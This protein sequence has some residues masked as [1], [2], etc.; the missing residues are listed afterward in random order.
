M[1]GAITYY[2]DHEA[3]S[4]EELKLNVTEQCFARI[5]DKTEEWNEKKWN[6]YLM[7]EIILFFELNGTYFNPYF[8]Q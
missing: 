4:S 6:F 5:H 1:Q 3:S 7:A 8:I 2:F